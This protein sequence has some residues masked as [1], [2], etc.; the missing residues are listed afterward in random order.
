MSHSLS[1]LCTIFLLLSCSS[2]QNIG[3]TSELDVLAGIMIGSYDSSEQEAADSSYY[4]ISLHM[5]PIWMNSSPDVHWLYVEQALAANQE[6]PYRQRVYKL[7][8]V[9]EK[10]FRSSVYTL[11]DPE[12]MIGAW[13]DEK[14]FDSITPEDLEEREG[15]AVLLTRIAPGHY[16]GQTEIGTCI[17]TLRGAAYATSEVDIQP[18]VILSW[19]RG[20][21]ADGNQVWGAEKGG[22]IFKKQ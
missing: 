8:K 3:G 6:A 12:A 9:G 15:C 16:A 13:Q 14:R 10:T 4:N 18:G 11:P 1:I 20:F 5:Y 21:D 17:S 22:Y 7:E 19:D 2:T